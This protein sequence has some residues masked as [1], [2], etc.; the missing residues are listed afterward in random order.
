MPSYFADPATN[1]DTTNLEFS[2]IKL[3]SM[4]KKQTR[5]APIGQKNR[6][7]WIHKKSYQTQ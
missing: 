5:L 7:N 1:F 3:F 2:Q 6:E 4:T